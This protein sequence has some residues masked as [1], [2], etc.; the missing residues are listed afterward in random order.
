MKT[1]FQDITNVVRKNIKLTIHKSAHRR[2]LLKWLYEVVNDFRYSQVT[3]STAV[4]ILDKY[5]EAKGLDLGEYQLIGI[6]ALFLGAKIEERKCKSMD[7]YTHVTDDTY[8]RQQVLQKEIEMLEL[9]DF[10]LLFRLPHS[11]LRAW[12][13]EKVSDRFTVEHRQEVFFCA[14]SY[15]MEKN[16]CGG[17]MYWIYLEGSREA[18]KVFSDCEIDTD[19]KF[20]L[21]NN[22]RIKLFS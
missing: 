16:I 6:S 20:Y 21:E 12:Y 3:F 15:V 4:F 19:F 18:E 14:F 8:S 22:R 17:N 11:F 1:A 2:K 7:D 10:N 5:T 9:F 13:L